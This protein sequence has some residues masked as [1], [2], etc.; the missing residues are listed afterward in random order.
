MSCEE[1]LVEQAARLKAAR[2]GVRVMGYRNIVKALPWFTAVRERLDDPA[3]SGWFIPFDAANTTPYHVPP[4]DDN[5]SPPRCSKLYHDL[6]QTP[7]FPHGDGVCPGPCDCGTQPCGEYL[8]DYTHADTN[9]LADWIVNEVVLG[10]NGLGNANL[11]GMFLDDEW[12]NTSMF[13][14]HECSGSPVGG[15]TEEDPHCLEDTGHANDAAYTTVMTDAWCAVRRRAEAAA[16]AAGGW[17][18]QM[19]SLFSTPVQAACAATLRAECAAGANSTFYNATTMHSLTGDHAT[20][21]NLAQDLATFLLLRGPYAFLGF[22]WSGCGAA[23]VFPE[24]LGRDYGE[25]TGFCSETQT[26]VFERDW[27]H[28]TVRMDCNA[29]VGTVVMKP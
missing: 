22:G 2:P 23:A 1:K 28:A 11:S 13:G 6:E 7:G 29:Y 19:F 24:E 18:W 14:P 4:C 26:G 25:P 16:I 3:T 15:P 20:L 27:T 12:Y 5:F 10:K 9:G 8:Y 17:F 21:P